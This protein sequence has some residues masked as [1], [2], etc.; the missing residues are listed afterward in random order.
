M[1]EG[2][3][4]FIK[5][6]F[7]ILIKIECLREECVQIIPHKRKHIIYY[8]NINQDNILNKPRYDEGYDLKHVFA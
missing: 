8:M 1:K 2:V 7:I 3:K 5:L 4:T 6:L